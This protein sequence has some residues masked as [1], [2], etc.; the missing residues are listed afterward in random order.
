MDDAINAEADG[1]VELAV[2]SA[3]AAWGDH[4]PNDISV[5]RD[6]DQF[7]TC[8]PERVSIGQAI[9]LAVGA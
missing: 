7:V 5:R 2:I 3:I 4:L 1:L 6:L 8:R 9:G